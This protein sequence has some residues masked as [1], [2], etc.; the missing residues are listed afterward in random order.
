M[1]A[2]LQKLSGMGLGC[3]F[4]TVCAALVLVPAL[5]VAGP[6]GAQRSKEAYV[7]LL[8]GDAFLLG[9]RVL[10]QSLR[11]TGTERCVCIQSAGPA[12]ALRRAFTSL[13]GGV[14][15]LV[16]FLTHCG[17]PRCP[18]TCWLSQ[19]AHMCPN[20]PRI[21]CGRMAGSCKRCGMYGGR[22]SGVGHSF[23]NSF[24]DNSLWLGRCW[25][26]VTPRM[27]MDDSTH[28]VSC[29]RLPTQN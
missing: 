3:T 23:S 18:G 13:G 1:R 10:G 5:V 16:I 25:A 6:E 2:G 20:L 11:E 4:L 19:S 27:D 8:Y 12:T 29:S 26:E 9:I 28:Q 21:L 17:F 14:V 7:S 22:R 24:Q 15:G